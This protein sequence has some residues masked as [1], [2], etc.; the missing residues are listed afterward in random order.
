M[1]DTPGPPGLHPQTLDRLHDTLIGRRN[2][3]R[4][5]ALSG[6]VGRGGRVLWAEAAD[7]DG[8][9]T[10]DT[11]FRVGSLT[12]PMVAVCVMRLES[13]GL[14]SLDD[15]IETHLPGAPGRGA[16]VRQLLCHT[17]GL[18]AEPPGPWWER[19]VGGTWNDL[20]GLQIGQVW[21][22][23]VR[24]HYSNVGY[25][26]LGRLV[27]TVRGRPWDEVLVDE[28]CRP[29]EMTSTGRTPVG[30][31]ATGWAVHPHAN[32]VHPE[33]VQPYGAMGPA[34][35]VWATPSDLVR[36]GMWL[37]ST[38]PDD[39]RVLSPAQ[40]ERMREPRVLVDEP[41]LSW[42][43]AH[44]LGPRITN[45]DGR[46]LVGHGGSVPG[47]TA[48]LLCDPRTG[49]TVAMCGSATN[50]V[51]D[52]APLLQVLRRAQPSHTDVFADSA[53]HA[54]LA[55]LCG[56]WY[57]GPNPYRLTIFHG[58]RIQLTGYYEQGRGTVFGWL[59]GRWVGIEG[60]YWLGEDLRAVRAGDGRAVALDV[61]TFH[62]T[63]SPYD[64]ATDVPG[65]AG[66]WRPL[67]GAATGRSVPPTP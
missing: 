36:F 3:R 37:G 4:V 57:W 46:K 42:T 55:E 27:E 14:V 48:E 38:D 7:S 66:R 61:G 54:E 45:V 2:S 21:P 20:A 9:T 15:R 56:T 24:F 26:V 47:F 5:P 40:R 23:G 64:P 30:P 41:G 53:G 51:M 8:T 10:A 6:A 28:V 32:L 59:N 13:E 33:P 35:E 31:A 60:G 49:D 17:A 19:S 62:L 63:R 52:A 16:T 39:D 1:N 34:G 12:K 11:A 67:P 18:P 29:L 50:D 25:A 43:T 22:A 58:P 65:G 44:G